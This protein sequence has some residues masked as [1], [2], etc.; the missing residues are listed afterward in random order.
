LTLTLKVNVAFTAIPVRCV[1]NKRAVTPPVLSSGVTGRTATIS[2]SGMPLAVSHRRT[3]CSVEMNDQRPTLNKAPSSGISES[4]KVAGEPTWAP[5]HVM[6][7]WLVSSRIKSC[8]GGSASWPATLYVTSTVLPK[9][10]GNAVDSTLNFIGSNWLGTCTS[11][12]PLAPNPF[13]YAV[14][15]SPSPMVAADGIA[16]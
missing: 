12:E 6:R 16:M 14:T 13:Q 7:G 5:S 8:K 15:V 10:G 9:L 3:V 1:V 2:R 4:F 11:H